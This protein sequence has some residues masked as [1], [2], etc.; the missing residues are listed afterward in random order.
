[1]ETNLAKLKNLPLDDKSQNALLRSRIDEQSQLIMILKQR[2]DEAVLK[3]QTLERINKELEDFRES[4]QEQLQLEFQKYRILDNRF[5]DLANNHEELIKFK[6]EYKRQ[7]A[8]LRQENERLNT[9]NK[10]LFSSAIE[11]KN[12]AVQELEK[13]NKLLR[14]QYLSLESQH[15]YYRILFFKNSKSDGNCLS[16]KLEVPTCNIEMQN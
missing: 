11:E 1:M 16:C 2:T 3:S 12:I 8:H 9:E 10:A 13:K 5:D 14:E 6:D 4:A 7:N 15:R